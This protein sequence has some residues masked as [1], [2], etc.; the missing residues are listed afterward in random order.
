MKWPRKMGWVTFVLVGGFFFSIP[1]CLVL[2]A[3]AALRLPVITSLIEIL[4]DG[5]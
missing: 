3:L 2:D 1:L 4:W 5:F